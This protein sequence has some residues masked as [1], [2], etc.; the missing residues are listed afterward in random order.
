L[1]EIYYNQ[2]CK[3]HPAEYCWITDTDDHVPLN[4]GLLEAWARCIVSIIF[5]KS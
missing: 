5:L 1:K 2:R 4:D 3:S